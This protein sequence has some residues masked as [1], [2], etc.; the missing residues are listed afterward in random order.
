MP[1]VGIVAVLAAELAPAQPRDYPHAGTVHRGSRRERV[2]EP[3]RPTRDRLLQRLLGHPPVLAHPQ[4]VRALGHQRFGRD[5]FLDVHW[6]P[7]INPRQGL[8]LF[9]DPWKV[10]LITSS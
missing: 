7:S 6:M 3:H 5:F 8:R 2:E 10:R 1:R 4:L 9:Y